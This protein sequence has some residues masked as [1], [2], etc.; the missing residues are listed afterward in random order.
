MVKQ[1][2]NG[3]LELAR[4]GSKIDELGEAHALL[5]KQ[6][7]EIHALASKVSQYMERLDEMKHEGSVFHFL[8]P[9]LSLSHELIYGLSLQRKSSTQ[10]FPAVLISR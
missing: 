10:D 2:K 8:N 5:D 9:L 7:V 6:V 4:A 1:L 3:R